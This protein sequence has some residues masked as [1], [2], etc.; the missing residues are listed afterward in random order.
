MNWMSEY[1]SHPWPECNIDTIK[2]LLKHKDTETSSN[3]TH[4][5]A[6]AQ[7]NYDPVQADIAKE[8]NKPDDCSEVL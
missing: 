6:V 7:C 3:L 1:V 8:T 4:S 5:R 2:Y